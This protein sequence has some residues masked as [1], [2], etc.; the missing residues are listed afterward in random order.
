M[1]R[2]GNPSGRPD[3]QLSRYVSTD[4]YENPKEDFKTI[5]AKLERLID[6]ACAWELA[7]VGCGNGELLYYLRKR[8]PHW[9]LHGFDHTPEHIETARRF[10]G[11]EGVDFY[12][13][14][15]FDIGG[16]YDIVVAT[17]F[18]SLFPDVSRPLSAM[19]GLCR[20]GGYLLATGLFNPFDIEVRVEFCDNSSPETAGRWR[21]D[22]NRHCQRSVRAMLEGRVQSVEF[23]ECRYDVSIPRDPDRPIRVWTLRDEDGNT[24]L[25]NGAWQLANQ[26]LLVVRK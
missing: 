14:D 17:C 24:L 21:T 7:D 19:L 12:E 9:R 15:I 13:R 5:G 22:F 2:T 8:Y 25:V 16:R 6:T 4:R 1:S 3:P 10:P 20:P 11:L 23:E 26:T 18:L